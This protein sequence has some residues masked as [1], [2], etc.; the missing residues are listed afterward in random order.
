MASV[1]GEADAGR[2]DYEVVR[3]RRVGETFEDVS[4]WLSGRR[5]RYGFSGSLLAATSLARHN[6]TTTRLPDGAFSLA[7]VVDALTLAAQE[8]PFAQ[9]F[10]AERLAGRLL[11]EEL[12]AGEA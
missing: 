6:V 5:R 3:G 11:L 10:A 8:L 9:R 4:A 2:D 7:S 1:L 12:H